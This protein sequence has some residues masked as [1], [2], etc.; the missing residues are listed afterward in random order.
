MLRLC[1]TD[2]AFGASLVRRAPPV[3]KRPANGVGRPPKLSHGEPFVRSASR[4]VAS[5][6]LIGVGL[7]PPSM[8]TSPARPFAPGLPRKSQVAYADVI[9]PPKEWPPTT[10]LPPSFFARRTTRRRSWISVFIPHCFAN[11]TLVSGI[12]WTCGE[13]DES[14]TQPT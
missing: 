8:N 1:A 3:L 13:I 14:W 9:E 7:L 11:S 4:W 6:L 12:N 5:S 10:T 2:G